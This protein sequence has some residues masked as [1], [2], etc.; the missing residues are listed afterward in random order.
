MG[1]FQSEK[2]FINNKK[3][4]LNEIVPTKVKSKIFIKLKESI[5]DNSVALGIRMHEG[6][7]KNLLYTAGGINS[8]GFYL[9]AIKI[10]SKKIKNPK[11]Y[12]FS[13]KQIFAENLCSDLKINKNNVTFVTPENGYENANDNLWLMSNFKN[14]IISNST[15]YWWAAYLSEFKYKKN[16][17]ICTKDFPNKDTAPNRWIKI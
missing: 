4:I 10:I 2:Y 17:I 1:L 8:L 6:L 7:P 14:L 12:L 15:L 3:I 5:R 16:I 13:S 11:F 9:K